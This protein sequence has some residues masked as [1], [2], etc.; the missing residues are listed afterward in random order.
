MR[1]DSI[2]LHNNEMYRSKSEPDTNTNHPLV[3]P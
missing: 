3:R 1:G 2:F